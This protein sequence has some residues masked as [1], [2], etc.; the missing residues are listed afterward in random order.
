M[1]LAPRHLPRLAAIVGLFTRYG[2]ADFAQRQGLRSLA[3][4]EFEAA[5]EQGDMRQKAVAFRKR[6]VELGPAYVKLG[7]VLSTRPDL[8]PPPYIEELE[9]LQDDVGEVPLE[10]IT[11]TIEEDLGTRISKLFSEFDQD[12]LGSASLGQVHAARLRDGRDVVVKV[13]RPDVRERVSA[14]MEFFREVA[15]FLVSHTKAGQRMDLVGVIEQMERS[16]ADELDYRVEA[17]NVATFRRALAGFPHLLVPRVIEAYTSSRVLTMERIRGRKIDDIPPIARVE[18]DFTALADEFAKAYLKQ[19]TIDGHF[20]ADPHPGNVF[21]VLPGQ[22]N[23]STPGELASRDRRTVVRPPVTPLSQVEVEA[24]ADAADAAAAD[25]PKLALIDFGMTAHLS[26][27]M[28]EQLVRLLMALSENRGED[29][30]NT[31][32]EV[33]QTGD[34]FER[35]AY[36]RETAGIISRNFGLS[37]G[38]LQSGTLMFELIG[39]AFAHGLRLPPELTLLGKALFNIDAVT[40]ALDPTYDPGEAIREFGEQIARD[41]AKRD[42]SPSRLLQIA[43]EASELMNHLPHRLDVITER[44]ASNDMALRVQLPQSELLTSSMQKI[45]NRIFSGLVLAGILVA[46]GLLMPHQP[47]LGTIGFIIAGLIGMYMVVMILFTDRHE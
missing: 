1:L 19:I 29:A 24:Q 6:L 17:R 3:P 37:V 5:E 22:E 39:V 32:I 16:L 41:H 10:D 30:A 38:E 14:E 8:L 18:H 34:D 26:N 42:L 11:A 43:S 25:H 46:S 36:M 35:D 47:T 7:Q 28:R 33:G 44:L 12:P 15:S 31:L 20:H 2:L 27:R 4:D 45:A 21:I 40:R 9:R 13:Q 23:P